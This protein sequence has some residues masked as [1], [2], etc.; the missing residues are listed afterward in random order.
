MPKKG[1]AP[2]I[3]ILLVLAA[4][5]A[6][7]LGV[8]FK[9]IAPAKDIDKNLV[10]KNPVLDQGNNTSNPLS[11]S[12]LVVKSFCENSFKGPLALNDVGVMQA[13]NLLSQRAIQSVSTIGPSPSAALT[14]FAG[15]RYQGVPDQGFSID[16]TS[17]TSE[18]ATVKTTWKYSTGSVTKTFS[19]VKEDGN[20]KIDSIQ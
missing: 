15:M 14:H 18:K 4:V 6:A 19:L 17:E 16:E 7:G 9:F 2:I 11:A 1:F 10:E 12:A 3:V 20:W 5:S 13:L 8:W